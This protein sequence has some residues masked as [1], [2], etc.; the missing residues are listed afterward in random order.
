M[1]PFYRHMLISWSQSLL[2]STETYSQILS[3][4]LWF[5]KHIKIESTA[6]RFPKFSDKDINVILQLFENG[7]LISWVNLKNRYE[8]TNDVFF[9]WAQLKHAVLVRRDKLNFDYSDIDEN[10]LYQNHHVIKGARILSLHK[11]SCN[12]IYSILI[13]NNVKKKQ[14][15]KQQQQLQTSNLKTYLKIQL[16]IGVKFTCHHV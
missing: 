6:I 15:N 5:T 1:L 4:F 10:D 3:Q 2:G 13:W 14:K 9:Q 7:R 12:K 16:L 11:L 8:L